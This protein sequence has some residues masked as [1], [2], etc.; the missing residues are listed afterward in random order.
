MVYPTAKT[1][2][3]FDFLLLLIESLSI[4]KLDQ[5][6]SARRQTNQSIG[7]RKK[8]G[9]SLDLNLSLYTKSRL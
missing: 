6:N 1:E 3:A 4:D 8:L 7:K 5:A 9:S 2:K